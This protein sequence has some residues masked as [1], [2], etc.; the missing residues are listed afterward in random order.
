MFDDANMRQACGRVADFAERVITG[1]RRDP[2]AAVNRI[3]EIERA[4]SER[5]DIDETR[6]TANEAWGRR[7]LP[8]AAK[9]YEKIADHLSA[10]ERKR[11]SIAKRNPA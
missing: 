3:F 2:V 7:D 5:Y 4:R 6:R 8:H 1:Y 11:L 10:V 9:L